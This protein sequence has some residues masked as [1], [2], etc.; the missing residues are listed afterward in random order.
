MAAL[1]IGG[2]W[3][4]PAPARTLC[5]VA[6]DAATGSVLMQEGDCAQQV[7]PASTFKIAI[8]L[9]GFDAGILQDAH[10][11]AW[12]FRPAYPDWGG[13]AWRQSTDAARWMKYSVFWFS[14]QVTQRLGQARFQQYT[15]A[16]RYGNQDVS[17][18]AGRHDGIRGAW[19]MS[20]LRISPL[21][22]VAFLRQLVNRQLPV[23]ARAFDM[24]HRITLV[25]PSLGGWEIHGKTGTGSPG[26]DGR[27]DAA[28]AY[29]WFVGWAT[30]GGRTLVFARLTQDEAPT[31]PNAGLRARDDLLGRFPAW[32][33][34]LARLAP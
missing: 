22:Q 26:S 16:F 8:S 13:A 32:A 31:Q 10:T 4:A 17:G 2:S 9:M 29:G 30:R 21:E 28:H 7:T 14:Q 25:A 18:G 1:L 19:V 5:T 20:S 34:R 15:R 24:T 11:P 3:A 33:D 27:Y 23:S 6:A 12:P